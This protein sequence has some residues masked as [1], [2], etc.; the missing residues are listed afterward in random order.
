MGIHILRISQYAAKD[1]QQGK[2]PGQRTEQA[3]EEGT[4]Q[5]PEERFRQKLDGYLLHEHSRQD[6]LH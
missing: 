6:A 4:V 2:A 1:R 3:E 5:V